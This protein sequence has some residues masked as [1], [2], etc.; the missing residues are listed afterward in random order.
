MHAIK[1]QLGVKGNLTKGC[2]QDVGDRTQ[3]LPAGSQTAEPQHHPSPLNPRQQQEQCLPQETVDSVFVLW[4]DQASVCLSV[5]QLACHVYPW[6]QDPAGEGLG[7]HRYNTG[8]PIISQALFI[9]FTFRVR[10]PG[11]GI[12]QVC[13]RAD[14]YS[15]ALTK[16]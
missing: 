5:P 16:W 9:T 2:L 13:Q 11:R 3:N 1:E 15:Q 14:L 8:H 4:A 10:L 7:A 12:K 6:R